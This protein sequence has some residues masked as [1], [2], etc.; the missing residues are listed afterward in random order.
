MP[1][2][3]SA[4][5]Y[6]TDDACLEEPVVVVVDLFDFRHDGRLDEDLAPSTRQVQIKQL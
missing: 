4:T 3:P 5:C 1:I 2:R 6:V